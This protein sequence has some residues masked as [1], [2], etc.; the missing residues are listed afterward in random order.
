LVIHIVIGVVIASLLSIILVRIVAGTNAAEEQMQ[1]MLD[2]T[3][4]GMSFWDRNNRNIN[5]NEEAVRLF[6]LSNKQEYLDRF[7]DLSPEYQKDGIPSKEKA[8]ECIQKAFKEGYHRFL[9]QHQKLN[10][11][12][13]PC[14]ITLVRVKYKND[15]ILAG[16]T[17]DL[18][19]LTKLMDE[20]ENAE[21]ISRH[22]DAFLTNISHEIR[23]PMNVILGITEIQLQN[24]N[25]SQETKE[26][27]INIYN[28]GYLLLKIINNI[29]DL[30]KIEAGKLE[31]EAVNYNA[32]DLINDTLNMFVMHYDHKPIRFVINVDENI[33]LTLF[34]DDL[35]IKQILNNLLTNAFKYTEQ[36]EVSFSVYVEPQN[37]PEKITDKKVMLVFRVQD[38]GQG[39]TKEQVDKL[40]EEYTRFN[41]DANRSVEGI[42]L[43][44]PITKYLVQMMNGEI[45]VESEPGEGSVFTVRLPQVIVDSAVLGKIVS[46]NMKQ[47]RVGQSSNIIKPQ[48]DRE[49]MPYGRI[50]IVDDVDTNLYVAKGLMD[51]YGLSIETASSGYEA[52]EK[53]KAGCIYDIVFMDHFMPNMDGM[54]TTEIMRNMGYKQ[55]VIALTANAMLGQAEVFIA[56][57]FNGFVSKPIDVYQLDTILN[58]FVRD[59]QSSEVVEAARKLKAMLKDHSKERSQS[60]LDIQLTETFVKEAEKA[61]IVLEKML[62]SNFKREDDIQ[63]YIIKVHSMKS[64]LD[65]IYEPGYASLAGELERAGMDMNLALIKDR[66]PEFLES[67]EL[68]IN[69]YKPKE[70]DRQVYPDNNELSA[71]D[72]AFLREKLSKIKTACAVFNKKEVKDALD[73]LRQKIWPRRI[74]NNIN[75]ISVHLLHSAF[76]TIVKLVEKTM[77]LS[78]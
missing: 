68:L 39:M 53:I 3:P 59:I 7:F 56:N 10:G 45:S 19:E 6:E 4:L 78:E 28:S 37:D 34:G 74:N 25:L 48:I 54:Q 20:K 41:L 32:A 65:N 15:Y 47:F 44:M 36:G 77:E 26:A 43:G 21:H 50:L 29:L 69:K 64:A 55:P 61:V 22:K 42:G 71:E 63:T 11:E 60:N 51:L 24:E 57:G 27:L 76:K 2:A 58:K 72:A 31:I 9:W 40:F 12:I 62:G 73:E 49:Y 52:I 18:R 38:T 33:P 30:S 66:T 70:K 35:R 14:E 5:T 46:D 17:R 23:T 1:I 13:I 75:E 67:L 16:Y 8:V